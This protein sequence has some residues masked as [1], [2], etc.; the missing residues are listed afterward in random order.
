MAAPGTTGSTGSGSKKDVAK[1]EASEVK[2]T[3][4]DAGSNVAGTAKQEAG[5]VV[6]EVG[7]QARSLLDQLRSD[8]REQGGAQKDKIASTLH[9]WSKE[10]ASMASKSEEDG[11]V[12]DLARQA[13]RRGGE[14][15]HWLDNHEVGDALDE[16]KRYGRRHPIAFL[17]ICAA[18]GVVV[19]RL[20]RSA[21]AT[22]TSLDSPNYP[23][24][25]ALSVGNTYASEQGVQGPYVAST[26]PYGAA[27]DP[28]AP[29]TPGPA[30]TWP[31]EQDY[32][33]PPAG[34]VAPDGPTDPAPPSTGMLNGP[35]DNYDNGGAG[36]LSGEPERGQGEY[37]P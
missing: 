10:L 9:S 25:R 14:I 20:T 24:A 16:V 30:Q 26:G 12:A 8:V 13:S 3:A 22:N 35:G 15:A 29:A 28:Y 1:S 21:V 36:P 5:N 33:Q 11:P 31:A 7:S 19:G 6:R 34:Y 23:S 18:A 27:A 32:G 4:L 2:D 37:R 17:G